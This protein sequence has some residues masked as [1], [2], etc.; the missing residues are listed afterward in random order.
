MPRLASF[1]L[2][3]Y[4]P[5]PLR[6]AHTMA[7]VPRDRRSLADVDGLVLGRLL[8]TAA[9]SSTAGGA[10]L[11]RWALFA[12]W[13][14]AAAR[15]A[16][17]AEHP[18]AARWQRDASE[19]WSAMLAPRRSRGRW[20]GVDPF[21]DARGAARHDETASSP[22][23]ASGTASWGAGSRPLAQSPVAVLTRATVR[24]R[25][26]HPFS[27]ARAPVD[28]EL[29]RARGLIAVVGMG[30]WPIG[31]QATFSLWRDEAAVRAF[32]R[33]DPSHANVVRRTRAEHWYGEELFAAFSVVR[34]SGAWD[35]RDP[36][37]PALRAARPEDIGVLAA[38]ERAA[39]RRFEGM[40][41]ANI[42]ETLPS[43]LVA[44]GQR[45]GR[46]W[47]AEAD[48]Q[49]VGFALVTEVD[50]EAHLREIAVVPDHGGQGIG[51]AL[52][53]EVGR[54]AARRGLRTL[55]LTTF[56]DVAW[57]GPWY[58]RLGFRPLA[59]EERGAGLRGIV[60]DEAR[61]GLDM[62]RRTA[63]RRVIGRRAR[64]APTTTA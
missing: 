9:G 19:R 14:D 37:A 10:D 60:D 40:G 55:T 50:G 6:T 62:D 43:S 15:E 45:E 64:S 23:A 1:D 57:N 13:E 3:R 4:P 5:S 33:D 16:F 17:E 48:G 61:A 34:H 47:V 38:V 56:V 30:E 8:G 32:A 24:A 26:I 29:H 12:V 2:V 35:G 54:W 20:A 25:R 58:E 42:D 36:L 51:T 31:Q 21:G 63:M 7:R 46:L 41:L 28:A 52:V 53:E 22:P 44:E 18:I 11:A 39:G 27:T 49:V 59:P